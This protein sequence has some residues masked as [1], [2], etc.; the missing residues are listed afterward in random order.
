MTEPV[1]ETE[2]LTIRRWSNSD[3]RRVLEIYSHPEVT[4]HLPECAVATLDEAE[5]FLQRRL[6]SYARY[7]PGYGVWAAARKVDGLVVGTVMLKHLPG[8]G[9]ALTEDVEVGWHL[10]RESWGMGYGTEMARGALS[11]G[12]L[13]QGESSILAVTEAENTRSLA[14]MERLGMVHR[15]I[16]RAYYGQT[17]V[18]Y[19]MTA[20]RWAA[21]TSAV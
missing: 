13:H 3:I 15:G 20:E 17:C 6:A 16:T 14:V 10:G 19:E 2:R 1:F 4:E 5:T 12:F 21:L 18:L 11:H 7:G 8:D 9:G